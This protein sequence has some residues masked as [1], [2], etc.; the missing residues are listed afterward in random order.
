V[1]EEKNIKAIEKWL[2][3]TVSFKSFQCGPA[4][5]PENAARIFEGVRT[6]LTTVLV[7]VGTYESS[8]DLPLMLETFNEKV[9]GLPLGR[10]RP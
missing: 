8:D 4:F 10:A 6:N 3:R 1:N 5:L 2:K 7:D 9:R